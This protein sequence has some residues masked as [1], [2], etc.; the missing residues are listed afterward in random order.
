MTTLATALTKLH[1]R[2]M[3]LIVEKEGRTLFESSASGLRAWVACI[4]ECGDELRGATAIDKIVG[5]AA[6]K[7]CL[8]AGIVEVLAETASEPAL[9]LLREKG[10]PAQARHIVPHIL[11]RSGTDVCPMEKLSAS[12]A[13]PQAFYVAVRE[14][15]T[16]N[17]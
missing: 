6:A 14:Q 8:V 10:V 11:N 5:I 7:L 1:Q 2:G 12:I 3:A 9:T 13:E 15:F 16:N 17:V 4:A